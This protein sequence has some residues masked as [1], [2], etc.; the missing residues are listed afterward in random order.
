MLCRFTLKRH[1]RNFNHQAVISCLKSHIRDTNYRGDISMQLV[2][3]KS[4]I[5][6]Y[7][8]HWINKLR[9]LGVVYWIFILSQLW[10][11]AWPVIWLLEKRYEV[12]DSSWYASHVAEARNEY[13]RA[14]QYAHGRDEHT[15]GD[16]WAPA[17]KQAAWARRT[18]CET[19][20]LADAE[21]LQGLTTEQLLLGVSADTEAEVERRQRMQRGEG[22]FMDSVVGL[23]R[24]V[25]EVRQGWNISM[26]WGG[27]V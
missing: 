2:V 10:I 14:R 24:G 27:N 3:S 11:F 12:V 15:L 17:V 18:N 22:N 21:R 25:N 7:S 6:V 23:A 26:G 20:L 19:V 13:A 16:F 5:T 4:T 1:V 9:N 8:P